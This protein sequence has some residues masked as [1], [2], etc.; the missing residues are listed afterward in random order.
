MEDDAD[1]NIGI[2]GIMQKK[3]PSREKRK[4]GSKLN[5]SANLNNLSGISGGP[6]GLASNNDGIFGDNP[7][8]LYE[9]SNADLDRSQRFRDFLEQ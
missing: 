4:V 8:S 9:A 5:D 2:V 6:Y 7:T 3:T 1:K